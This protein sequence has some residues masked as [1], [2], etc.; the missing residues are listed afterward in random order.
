MSLLQVLQAQEALCQ[1]LKPHPNV[2][3]QVDVPL[4]MVERI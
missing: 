2:S 1:F 4:F 3:V